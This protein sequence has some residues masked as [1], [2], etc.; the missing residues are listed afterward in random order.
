[1]N[2]RFT[3]AVCAAAFLAPGVINQS[4]A[5][6]Q[7]IETLNC[8]STE[9]L[10]TSCA[11]EGEIVSAGIQ[12]QYGDGAPCFLGFTWGFEENGI[13]T[14]NGCSAQFAVTIERPSARPIVDPEVL[15]ERLRRTR[16]TLRDTRRELVKEQESRR[17]LEA[18]LEEV[19]SALRAAEQ[20]APKITKSKRKPQ[21]AIRSVAV[22]SNKAVR[23]AKKSGASQSRVVEIVSARPTQGSWLVIGRLWN[24]INGQRSTSYFR[25]WTEKGEVISYNNEI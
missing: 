8:Q 13:W 24:E 23:D 16:K 4:H 5:Q 9:G 1:M 17:A 6:E 2:I 10:R 3:L 7:V 11:V 21:T 22:C 20:A 14:A 19:Q 15:K 18:E 12:R 25:C